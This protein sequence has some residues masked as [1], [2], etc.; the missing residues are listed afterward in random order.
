[1]RPVQAKARSRGPAPAEAGAEAEAGSGA[2]TGAGV[3]AGA[4]P[5]T[6]SEA[7]AAVNEVLERRWV[8]L[9]VIGEV[10]GL[11]RA[12][13][14]HIYFSLADQDASAQLRV[15][16]FRGVASALP[17]EVE[18]GLELVVHGPFTVYA[19]RGDLQIRAQKIE[20]V[21]RGALQL[22]FEQLRAR[23]EAEGLFAAELKRALPAFPRR[24][25]VVTS[26]AGAAL[27]DVIH[28]SARCWPSI[29]LLLSPTRVQGEGAER[30]IVRAL[31]RIAQVPDVDVVLL[32]RGGGS[33]ED[34][35][36]FNSEALARAVRACRVPVVSGVGHETDI[37]I[38]DLSADAR[39][40]TPSAAA[41]LAL[42]D[43]AQWNAHA[44]TL[45]RGLTQSLQVRMAEASRRL[46]VLHGRL[47][48]RAPGAELA[49]RRRRWQGA[50]LR[51]S[52][53]PS[54]LLQEQRMQQRT[55]VERL[56]RAA[57]ARHTA[58]C[59]QVL[60]LQGKLGALSPQ[61]VLERGYAIAY[62]AMTGEGIA[63]GEGPRAG[64]AGGPGG[65][66]VQVLRRAAELSVGEE[67]LLQ[68]HEG[69][70]RARVVS[71]DA[72]PVPSAS[73]GRRSRG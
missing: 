21:G 62:R 67:F 3:E 40:A 71:V 9:C 12:A 28:V 30:E 56:L 69:M 16:L 54:A 4:H 72:E 73:P 63:T 44:Q 24:V 33:P 10:C 37:T 52:Q 43:R 49:A 50:S 19:P 64:K 60:S 15:A 18:E 22:A 14:G 38:A 42:P 6:V 7:L 48:A 65:K 23:L 53:L 68:L 47:R 11:F 1:M 61:A 45:R 27:H 57:A 26:A 66:P 32:V 20:P 31:Q 29:P 55:L 2:G 39:A 36:A 46:A 13:S 58:W 70:L 25:G 5:L 35:V 8:R 17:F 34:L 41:A 59:A 51:L